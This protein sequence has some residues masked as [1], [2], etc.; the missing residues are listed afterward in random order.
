MI[1]V[2]FSVPAKVKVCGPATAVSVTFCPF[3][4]PVTGADPLLQSVGVVFEPSGG[5]EI[6]YTTLP[7]IVARV[8]CNRNPPCN[9]PIKELS[10]GGTMVNCQL[11]AS[12]LDAACDAGSE[13]PP[14][15]DSIARVAISKAAFT[16]RLRSA[17]ISQPILFLPTICF[18][19]LI[20]CR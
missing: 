15:A 3:T 9:P 5:S 17:C 1:V 7:V 19:P 8:G 18:L 10:D 14:Q 6:E 12:W 11:P 2:P 16:S 20:T 4:V 13:F